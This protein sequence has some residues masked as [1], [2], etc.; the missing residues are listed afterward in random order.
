MFE[1]KALSTDDIHSRTDGRLSDW[2]YTTWLINQ[3]APE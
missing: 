2:A 1:P 3:D